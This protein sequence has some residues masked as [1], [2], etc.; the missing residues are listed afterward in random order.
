LGGYACV[1]ESPVQMRIPTFLVLSL[2][3]FVACSI[4]PVPASISEEPM[5]RVTECVRI[6]DEVINQGDPYAIIDPVWW[7]ANIYEGEQKYNES[8]APFS[9]E[10]RYI[11]AVIWY[12]AEVN[13][14]GHDQF[15]FNSTG[16]VWK[17]ALAGFRE[18]GIDE[19]V[20]IIQESAARMGGNP[21]LDRATRQEQ[22]DTYQPN[23]DDLDTR[24]YELEE[25]VD[26]DEAMRRYILQH[27]SAFYFE[28]EVQKLKP[29]SK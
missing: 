11:F 29:R 14:G 10:Q 5:E 6:D 12:I 7:T 24:F 4:N 27:R 15:Y 20:E 23:F 19:A 8:L 28:G 21:S 22:L 9:Q 16:I 2:V 13:N 18:L 3:V 25:N 1:K 26:I 17:D